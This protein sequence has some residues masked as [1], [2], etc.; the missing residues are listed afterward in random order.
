MSHRATKI[1]LNIC[2]VGWVLSAIAIGTVVIST[3]SLSGVG[4]AALAIVSISLAI[5]SGVLFLLLQAK[6]REL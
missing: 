3:G 2:L 1:A 6:I 4:G 5:A